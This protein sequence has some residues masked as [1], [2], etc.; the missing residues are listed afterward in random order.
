MLTNTD[1][2]IGQN[3]E[4][5][6]Y[7]QLDQNIETDSEDLLDD[8]P[9]DENMKAIDTPTTTDPANTSTPAKPTKAFSNTTKGTPKKRQKHFCCQILTA[10]QQSS[11]ERAALM[12]QLTAAPTPPTDDEIDVL[13][14]CLAITVNK[15]SHFTFITIITPRS[16]PFAI[17]Q[18]LLCEL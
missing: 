5:N 10:I 3:T 15:C 4:T 8:I 7:T 11:A 13:F 2:Q 9:I 18:L 12:S 17:I 6:T 1:T 14:N 16:T